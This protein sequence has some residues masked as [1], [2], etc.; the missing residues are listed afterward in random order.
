[1]SLVVAPS[2]IGVGV[3]VDVTPSETAVWVI[4]MLLIVKSLVVPSDW[5][6]TVF[7]VCNWVYVKVF[8]REKIPSVPTTKEACVPYG[9]AVCDSFILEPSEVRPVTMIVYSNPSGK[10]TKFFKSTLFQ[11]AVRPVTLMAL[12]PLLSTT[13]SVG[14]PAF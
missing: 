4:M 9:L 1:M 12:A 14:P 8:S 6:R 2:E 11:S 10:E 3:G 5:I 7:S 13:V